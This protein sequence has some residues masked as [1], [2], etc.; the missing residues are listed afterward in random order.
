MAPRR[1]R[2]LY[3]RTSAIEQLNALLQT[4]A[5]SVVLLPYH[6][7]LWAVAI[8][9]ILAAPL[10]HFLYNERNI[11]VSSGSLAHYSYPALPSLPANS[12]IQ[13]SATS[14]PEPTQMNKKIASPSLIPPNP[15][16]S[17]LYI[18]QAV[19][20]GP[21]NANPLTYSDLHTA[22]DPILHLPSRPSDSDVPYLYSPYNWNDDRLKS[23]APS[24]LLTPRSTKGKISSAQ[25]LILSYIS[26]S[27]EQNAAW[28]AAIASITLNS[29]SVASPKG[30]SWD[31]VLFDDSPLVSSSTWPKLSLLPNMSW[32]LQTV[33]LVYGLGSFLLSC[34]LLDFSPIRSKFG[35]FM[36]VVVEIALCLCAS[37]S[38]TSFL[39]P[40]FDL[41]ILS[42]L[43]ALPVL[44]CLTTAQNSL[45]L[46]NEVSRCPREAS[47]LATVSKSYC[48]TA[49]RAIL[50]TFGSI[51]IF[52]CLG[53]SVL[54]NSA[55]SIA[56]VYT[57]IGLLFSL[58][59]HHTYFAAVLSVDLRRL[60]LDELID[61]S[62]LSFADL[63]SS[64]G[65]GGSTTPTTTGNS[66]AKIP[67]WTYFYVTY[68]QPHQN[69]AITA[70][71]IIIYL[72]ARQSGSAAV[73]GDRSHEIFFTAPL[74]SGHHPESSYQVLQP[75]CLE[76]DPLCKKFS[77]SPFYNT[78]AFMFKGY[79]VWALAEIS[80]LLVIILSGAAI[81]LKSVL[82]EVPF[83]NDND[84]NSNPFACE[85]E[86][87]LAKDLTGIHSLD[88]FQ[89]AVSDTWV[90]TLSFDHCVAVWVPESSP[91]CV[92][93][94]SC[95]VTL[96][97]PLPIWPVSKMLLSKQSR[98]L[99][100]IS[101][102]QASVSL[103]DVDT[104]TV[105]LWIKNLSLFSSTSFVDAFLR[106]DGS[107]LAFGKRHFYQ[108]DTIRE[109]T[110]Q[111]TA[112]TRRWPIELLANEDILEVHIMKTPSFK[113][114]I[115]ILTSFSRIL[116]GV[117][118]MSGDWVFWPL[119][120]L[121]SFSAV[122]SE[123]NL[124]GAVM[125]NQ[126][127]F[128]I[129]NAKRSPAMPA[130]TY[131][132]QD[133]IRAIELVEALHLILIAGDVTASL[134]DAKTG[135]LLRHFHVGQFKKGT[136]RVF[137]APPTH[138]RF[139][140]CA[141]VQ[142][143]SIAYTNREE[144]DMVICHTLTIEHRARNNICLRVERDPRETRCLGFEATTEQQ[145]WIS[146]VEAWDATDLNRLMGIRR[147]E[148]SSLD[149][150][151]MNPQE[152]SALM[153]P[154][155]G[156][157]LNGS[158][159]L[160]SVNSG[161]ATPTCISTS[162]SLSPV[163]DGDASVFSRRKG[164]RLSSSHPADAPLTIDTI[165]PLSMV[166]EGWIM[167]DTGAVSFYEIPDTVNTSRLLIPRVGPIAK[168]GHKSL[169]VVFGNIA[170][171]IYFGKEETFATAPLA[172]TFMG[173][174]SRRKVA[175]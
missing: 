161:E 135:V 132:A 18:H 137:H 28:D 96:S 37:A 122:S 146:S 101:F 60:E 143:I 104:G 117:Q 12:M 66:S 29:S 144:P 25:G 54:S 168:Y 147:K 9:F 41:V 89:L 32:S 4:V 113:E 94:F 106:P 175:Y 72:H 142:S 91:N 31:S 139:C 88:V 136:L 159:F 38:C 7:I 53:T 127:E 19:V 42:R 34:S 167:S 108:L 57:C 62:P 21:Y 17:P 99:A 163:D 155:P 84:P 98:T 50:V 170:K 172:A 13:V 85:R 111:V 102:K 128:V 131:T 124:K 133:P 134:V 30:P 109:K 15:N 26:N 83:Q 140:G 105:R 20:I 67:L 68:I 126:Q 173:S 56:C 80:I 87:L 40:S 154:K 65:G 157:D 46:I 138:C 165:P 160:T 33:I 23:L 119:S 151:A 152:L 158:P 64:G 81:I 92:S 51:G 100:L 16:S 39:F 93:N 145:H 116:K 97:V 76:F 69:S 11:Y 169:C 70:L 149:P 55:H 48:K 120:L 103:W 141:S 3:P 77:M 153:F 162:S 75:L 58:L 150:T 71:L 52:A 59:M 73:E 14:V 78:P 44:I 22:L 129:R 61:S 107:L 1:F 49:P 123:N 166:W 82:P 121:E 6:Y 112:K 114:T 86:L 95:L 27:S 47:P 2:L 43:L 8:S 130:N 5:R 164:R 35:I 79:I 148:A 110:A 125:N 74:V 90:A 118:S 171:L 115:I 174:R 36:A 63:S 10:L 45:R 24:V 156:N